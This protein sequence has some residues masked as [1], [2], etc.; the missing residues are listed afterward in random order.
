MRDF[1]SRVPQPLTPICAK[2]QAEQQQKHL[3]PGMES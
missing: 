1:D 3:T 2:P